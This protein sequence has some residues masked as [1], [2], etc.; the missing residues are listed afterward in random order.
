MVKE[1][2]RY[3]DIAVVEM[4]YPYQDVVQYHTLLLCHVLTA[5]MLV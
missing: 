1:L 4:K 3:M 5:E 2:D